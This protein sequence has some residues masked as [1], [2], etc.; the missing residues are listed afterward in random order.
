VCSRRPPRGVPEPTLLHIIPLRSEVRFHHI[1][2]KKLSKQFRP[3]Q[4]LQSS[5]SLFFL[6]QKKAETQLS[7]ALIAPQLRRVAFRELSFE[8]ELDSFVT[9]VVIN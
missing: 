5:S 9:S 6:E 8:T 7:T 3:S 2:H 1:I 4:R